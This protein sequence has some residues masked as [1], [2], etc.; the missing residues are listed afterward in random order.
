MIIIIQHVRGIKQYQILFLK[1]TGN[2]ALLS[3]AFKLSIEYA[4][5]STFP[6]CFFLLYWKSNLSLKQ[7]NSQKQ[8]LEKKSINRYKYIE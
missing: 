2:V 6:L 5:I 8:K 1:I 4:I 3:K 7:K